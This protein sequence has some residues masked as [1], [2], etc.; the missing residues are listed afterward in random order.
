LIDLN[1]IVFG[2]WLV[3]GGNQIVS[4]FGFAQHS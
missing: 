4:D 1:H 3:A 2:N